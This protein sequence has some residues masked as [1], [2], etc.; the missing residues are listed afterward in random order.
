[1]RGGQ[2]TDESDTRISVTG[3]IPNA[4]YLAGHPLRNGTKACVSVPAL[5]LQGVIGADFVR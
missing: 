4:A 5:G 2:K 1:M 3:A